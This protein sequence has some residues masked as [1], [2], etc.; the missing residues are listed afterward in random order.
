MKVSACGMTFVWLWV[1][2][3][4]LCGLADGSVQSIS[5]MAV[6]AAVHEHHA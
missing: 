1:S 4:L 2:V 6:A 5:S 3:M